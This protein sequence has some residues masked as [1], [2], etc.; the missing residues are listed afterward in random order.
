M[1]GRE[2][3]RVP[4]RFWLKTVFA[5]KKSHVCEGKKKKKVKGKMEGRLGYSCDGGDVGEC[6]LFYFYFY[7]LGQEGFCFMCHD[8][9]IGHVHWIRRW[10]KWCC[11]FFFFYLFIYYYYF[12]RKDDSCCII[13]SYILYCFFTRGSHV[14]W[15]HCFFP[16][17]FMWVSMVGHGDSDLWVWF[18]GA[19]VES[20]G[21]NFVLMA[22]CFC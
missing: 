5:D 18:G 13:I 16:N 8:V 3:V 11:I 10:T 20:L 17:F 2:G 15:I 14:N 9:W 7:F 21:Y 12:L 6:F 19:W 22:N 4:R 1:S